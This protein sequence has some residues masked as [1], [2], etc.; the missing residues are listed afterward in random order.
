MFTPEKM[1]ESAVPQHCGDLVHA[2]VVVIVV[3]AATVA[4]LTHVID[5]NTVGNVYLTAL[6]YAAGRAGS[7]AHRSFTTRSNGTTQ[8]PGTV[9]AT[10]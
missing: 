9:D 5:A 4:G 10:G 2:G 1:P 6:G 3:I 8:P 7:I